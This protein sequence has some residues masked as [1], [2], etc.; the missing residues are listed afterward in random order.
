[1]LFLLLSN[2]TF[3]PKDGKDRTRIPDFWKIKSWAS[4]ENE[5]MQNRMIPT[6]F[7]FFFTAGFFFSQKRAEMLT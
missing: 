5:D 3:V 6:F 1:M 7:L 2:H 4:Y